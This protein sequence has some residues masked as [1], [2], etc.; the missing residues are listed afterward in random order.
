M[1]IHIGDTVI[2]MHKPRGGYGYM[3]PVP[4]TVVRIYRVN[5]LIEA[6][7]KDGGTKI[8]TVKRASIKP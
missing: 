8:V 6:K 1:A 5:V 4:A 2:W 7:L 3:I